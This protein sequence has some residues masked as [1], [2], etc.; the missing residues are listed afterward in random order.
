[1][2]SDKPYCNIESIELFA[3]RPLSDLNIFYTVFFVGVN[4]T[5][6][7]LKP[8]FNELCLFI[9]Y[10]SNLH[11]HILFTLQIGLLMYWFHF[12]NS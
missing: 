1:M 8:F 9:M 10:Y 12:V 7:S 2:C 3:L 6:I 5:L 4:N 11:N